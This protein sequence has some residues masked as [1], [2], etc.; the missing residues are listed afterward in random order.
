MCSSAWH[1]ASLREERL[2]HEDLHMACRIPEGGYIRFCNVV[3]LISGTSVDYFDTT[4]GYYIFISWA[5]AGINLET[6][7]PVLLKDL[8]IPEFE[9]ENVGRSVLFHYAAT[10]AVVMYIKWNVC[11]PL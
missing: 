1:A 4:V 5:Y 11:E 10:N 8:L 7:V 6:N 9:R 2:T 3:R